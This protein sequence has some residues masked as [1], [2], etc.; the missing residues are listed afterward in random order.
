MKRLSAVLLCFLLLCTCSVAALAAE[1]QK[2]VTDTVITA[3]VPGSHKITV[4]A[5]GAQVFYEGTSVREFAVE[6]LGEARILV[7]AESGKL[8]KAVTVNGQDVTE[9][10]RMAIWNCRRFMRIRLSVLQRRM[11]PGFPQRTRPPRKKQHRMHLQPG[12]SQTLLRGG[13]C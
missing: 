7:R 12:I 4:L 3:V 11:P 1:P 9:N 10:C 8:I 6:R 13:A 5:D 2:E